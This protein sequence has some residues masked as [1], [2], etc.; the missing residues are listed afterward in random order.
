MAAGVAL[1]V[2]LGAC[3]GSS[4]SGGVASSSPEAACD[5]FV[6]AL[7][8]KVDE[9]VPI[10]IRAE[11]KDAAE[12]VA[13]QK[14]SCLKTFAAPG[15]TTTPA[16]VDACTNA[17][18]AAS[19]DAILTRAP[20][21][22][23]FEGSLADGTPCG[24]GAQCQGGACNKSGANACG[25]CTQRSAAGGPCASTAGCQSGLVCA[26][27][28]CVAPAKAGASCSGS[29]PCEGALRCS[30]GVCTVPLAA[31]AACESG[32]DDAC[33]RLKALFCD[34][35]AKVCKEVKLA[36][37][38]EACGLV[39]GT[40]VGCAQGGKCK[41]SANTP[42]GT[43]LAAAADGQSCNEASGP[44]CLEPAKCV[45]GVCTI[46]DPGACK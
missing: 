20:D 22:C 21:A 24:D 2:W 5:S 29:I 19:C 4:S 11:Y 13:R 10:G 36:G 1:A 27:Q 34:P 17:Y 39:D 26:S 33:D 6:R 12:C 8:N 32:D 43:C 45:D 7:C 3:G 38:G 28:K 18:T 15:I 16:D 35:T 25:A 44:G 46:E 41:T 31:G 23:I 40:F 42:Q 14:Q 37:P 9:C 30:K